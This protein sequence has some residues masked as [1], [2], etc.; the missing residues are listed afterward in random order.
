MPSPGPSG[1]LQKP[2]S[3]HSGW[4]QMLASKL[5]T[6]VSTSSQLGSEKQMCTVAAMAG[7][8]EKQ[9][10]TT[11]RWKAPASVKT[12]FSCRTPAEFKD[13][14]LENI[15]RVLGDELMETTR[16]VLVLTSSDWDIDSRSYFH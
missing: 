8:K 2:F 14:R 7:P 9:C 4:V 15:D 10:G 6:I 5:P 13:T 12:F 16:G 3:G 1:T 11:F